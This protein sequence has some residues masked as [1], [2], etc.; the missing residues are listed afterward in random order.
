MVPIHIS[1]AKF[2][3]SCV[4][5]PEVSL[6]IL[7]PYEIVTKHAP[8]QYPNFFWSDNFALR[9]CSVTRPSQ[10]HR[11]NISARPHVLLLRIRAAFPALPCAPCVGRSC[12]QNLSERGAAYSDCPRSPG[13]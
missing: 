2:F 1:N 12:R 7:S 8:S 9:G 11:E 10:S 6:S 3:D 13:H 4:T 5:A